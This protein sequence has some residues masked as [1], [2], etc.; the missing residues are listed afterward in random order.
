MVGESSP[1]A[2]E[3]VYLSDLPWEEATTG[4]LGVAN[5]HLPTIDH[6]FHSGDLTLGD[7]AYQQGIGAY[8]LSEI[9]YALDGEYDLFVSEIGLDRSAQGDALARFSVFVNGIL[10]YEGA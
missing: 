3:W 9:T 6:A 7:T 10:R 1:A 4:W 2:E 5:E 8:P